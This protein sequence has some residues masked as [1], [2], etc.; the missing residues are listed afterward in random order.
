MVR[1]RRL[2]DLSREAVKVLPV[3]YVVCMVSLVVRN[4]V[5]GP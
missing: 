5:S 4:N 3:I 2:A 1:D